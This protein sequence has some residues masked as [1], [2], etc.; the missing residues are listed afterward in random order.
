MENKKVLGKI[1]PAVL[2]LV[3]ALLLVITIS[4][5]SK[6]KKTPVGAIVDEKDYLKVDI[7]NDKT[8]SLSK[9]E[10]YN[11]LR[12][13]G[14]DAFEDALYEAALSDIAKKIRDDIE[15]NASN[16][17]NSAY[18]KKFIYVIDAECY[19][20]TDENEVKKL[21]DKEK[22]TKEKTFMNNVK[23]FGFDIDYSKGIY[24]KGVFDYAFTAMVKREYVRGVLL[25]E[26]EDEDSENKI[27]TKKLEEYFEKHLEERDKLGALYL[28]FSS[29]NEIEDSLKSLNLKYIGNKL[30]RVN[31]SD[32]SYDNVNDRTMAEYEEYYDNFDAKEG[33]SPLNENEVLFE[34]ARLYNYIYSYKPQLTLI[35]NGHNYLDQ[36]AHPNDTLVDSYSPDDISAIKAYSL[37]D[38]VANLLAQDNGNIDESPRLIYTREQI[39]KLSSTIY[40]AFYSS[41]SY[42]G[43][44]Y[45]TPSSSDADKNFLMFKLFDAPQADYTT[46]KALSDLIN[47]IDN[48][49]S[50]DV[51]KTN[52]EICKEKLD[53]ILTNLKIYND[54]AKAKDWLV[55]YGRNMEVNGIKGATAIIESS[56]NK[57]DA[58]SIWSKV[59]EEMLTNEYIDEKLKDYLDDECKITIYDSLF[60]VQFAQKYDFYK[61]GNKQSSQNV[62]KVK[63]GDVETTVT[64]EEMFE[65]L[66]KKYGANEATGLL[67]NQVLKDKYY[68]K[69]TDA[70]MKEYEKEYESILTYF[71]QGQS[72]QYGYSPAI[73]QKAFVNLYFKA[74]D[75]KE[76]IF[77]MWVSAELQDI[78]LYSNPTDFSSTLFQDFK[79]LTNVEVS[80]YVDLEYNFLY[81]YTDDDQDGEFDDWTKVDDTD[82][83]KIQVKEAAV[84]L[85]NLLNERAM[86]E[87]SN[88]NRGNAY[89]DLYAEYIAASKVSYKG[90][91]GDGQPIPTFTTT[92]EKEAYYFAQFKSQGI[93]L[94][95]DN[96]KHIDSCQGVY[97]LDDDDYETQIKRIYAYMIKN[98]SDDLKVDEIF[99][100][101]IE[102]TDPGADIDK[103]ALDSL[104]EFKHGYGTI[105]LQNTVEAPSF[106][107][108]EKDNSDTSTGSK[109]YPYSI[110]EDD[111]FPVGE[112]GKPIDNTGA[113]DSLYNT[114]DEVMINQLILYIRESKDG[115]ES[116]SLDV[117]NAFKAYFSEQ[118]LERYKSSTFRYYITLTLVNQYI[119]DSKASVNEGLLDKVKSL[120]EA[121][122]ESLF[123]FKENEF[124]T[125]WY[126]IFK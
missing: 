11:K 29:K 86:N 34:F 59:F 78:L 60:E 101:K 3:L 19:G 69:I 15:A 87:F 61:A 83:R 32:A 120:T 81:V 112:D 23:Q 106:K 72:E 64:A 80:S 22:E 33:E 109:V 110:N 85:I 16:L 113:E 13:V 67:F 8:Y 114:T 77:N 94:G 71:A 102:A 48:N 125:K 65:R 117:I 46:V 79:T 18:Y 123:E 98:H 121:K 118:T 88:S 30:Y 68:S 55:N 119:S 26:I 58:D 6:S 90:N 97:D 51:I 40:S 1:I 74:D 92:S 53:K 38:M 14:Y 54:D 103:V 82:A 12:Y 105:Y 75:K 76:A 104:F 36:T 21:K 35:I 93:F 49:E 43:V 89:N 50:E 10:F 5:C 57:E 73:G 84:K 111:P 124:I 4:S 52:L 70:K 27:T 99:A 107:F 56:Q 108:E 31:P 9:L 2:V 63:V 122:Q 95:I 41:Y 39:D 7:A 45:N 24:Q 42:Y 28:S 100:R 17:E 115:V 96:N 126:E 25:E 47:S 20:T 116:L 37:E 91:Y 66:E 62:L 44:K